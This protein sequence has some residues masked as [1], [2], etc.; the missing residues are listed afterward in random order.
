MPLCKR[1]IARLDVKGSRLIKGVRFEGLRVLG[2][3]QEKAIEYSNAGV[4]EIIYVDSVASLYGRNSLDN[5]LKETS[6]EVFIPITAGGG[7]RSVDDAARLLKSGA[8]KIAINSFA[9]S[10]PDILRELSARFGKQCVVLSVQAKR[11]QGNSWEAMAEGGRERSGRNV[12]SWIEE[13]QSLG[14]GEVLLTSVDMDGTCLG[15]DQ[16]LITEVCAKINVPLIVG[17]GFSSIED[18]SSAL[19]RERISGVSIGAALHKRKIDISEVKRVSTKHGIDVVKPIEAN[20]KIGSTSLSLQGKKF[21]IIDYGMGNVQSLVNAFNCIGA[22]V[23]VSSNAEGLMGCDLLALPGVGAFPAGMAQLQ[24][25]GL[26]HFLQT[27]A[28]DGKPLLGICLGM[29]MLFESSEEFC[30][31]EGLRILEGRINQINVEAGQAS[32]LPH[33]GWNQLI[34]TDLSLSLNIASSLEQYFVH[35][36]CANDV[37]SSTV[38]YSCRY[39]SKTPFPAAVLNGKVAGF[40]F[41]P[42]RSGATGIEL[43]HKI[44]EILTS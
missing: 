5:L 8:D 22:E 30:W 43:L 12:V 41:H 39:G 25:A 26:D 37:P 40:Q 38:L 31:C 10:N 27:W 21:G 29:Q 19:E 44:C 11:S 18:V 33:I 13:A 17:G 20:S 36:F 32:L 9:L 34:D 35:S 16:E 2:S 7:V 23:F 3:A 24:D 4:D 42:E 28:S 1:I 15:A 6:K 14:I